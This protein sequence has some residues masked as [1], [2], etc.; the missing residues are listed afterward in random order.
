[1]NSTEILPIFKKLTFYFSHVIHIQE[2]L[3]IRQQVALSK[4]KLLPVSVDNQICETFGIHSDLKAVYNMYLENDLLFF[5]NTGVLTKP[6]NKDNWKSETETRLFAHNVMQRETKRIDPYESSSGT[7]VLGRLADVLFESGHNV[8]SFSLE[9]FSVA[10]AG[11]PERSQQMI[12]DRNGVPEI[13]FNSDLIKD[14]HT[15]TTYDS[16]FF[17]ETWSSEFMNAINTNGLLSSEIQGTNLNTNFPSSNLSRNLK[18]VAELIATREA[19]GVDID[20]FYVEIGG[21]KNVLPC[22]FTHILL[23]FQIHLYNCIIFRI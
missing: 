14:F 12:L 15:S 13:Y 23:L 5:A 1:M 17:A 16:G 11:S 21:K 3:D 6:V 20:T 22:E 8:G 18:T 9:R 4:E 10:L 2:Y 7:G 19:R